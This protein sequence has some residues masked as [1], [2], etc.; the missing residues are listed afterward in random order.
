MPDPF[1][2]HPIVIVGTG[3]AGLM[4]AHVLQLAGNQVILVEKRKSSGRKLL[5][6]GSSGL[7]ITFDCPL[8]AF[9]NNY[10]APTG[11]ME[12][13]LNHF[14]PMNWLQFIE[15]LGIRT[16]KGT[17]RRYFIEGMKAAT[18]LRKWVEV[19]ERSGGIFEFQEELEDFEIDTETQLIRLS[20]SSG[21]QKVAQA[22][23]LSMGGGSWEKDE[24]PLRWPRIFER[25]GIGFTPFQSSNCGFQVEWPIRFLQEAEGQPI[26]NVVLTSSRGAR[27]GELVITQYGVE[28]TPVYFAGEV[29]IVNLDLK[30][31]LTEDQIRKKLTASRE[32]LSPIRRVKKNLNLS[33]AALAL[34][35]HMTPQVIL[36]DLEMLI[37]R[38]K[39]FPL[40]LKNRQPLSEAISSSGGVHWDE[41][42]DGLMLKKFPG[43][44]LAGEMIDWDAPTG[45][46]LIQGCVSM[47][48]WVGHSI[49]TYLKKKS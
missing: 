46:F 5:V 19:I 33:P 34:I 30:P 28:G 13:V 21:E 40:H 3:P 45:G 31:D 14:T 15:G 42:T 1:H 47:G 49:S 48:H 20:F 23:C 32:N 24:V 22:V 29:G 25:K 4:A 16:F 8:P 6:A 18:L 36:G 27:H 44:F 11:R 39:K 37:Q 9:I 2:S 7:N 43:V 10:S 38:L 17:S 26:K 12:R 41:L 35:F